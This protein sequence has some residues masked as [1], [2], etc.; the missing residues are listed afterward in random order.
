[1]MMLRALGINSALN[2]RLDR[3]HYLYTL[4]TNG[5]SHPYYLDE[6]TFFLG[7]SW[8][9]FHFYFIFNEHYVSKQNS[10]R[11]DARPMWG[12]SVCL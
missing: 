9:I 3:N 8:V 10:S 6:S 12:Y 1:M 11:W 4:V 2:I 5:F 7:A